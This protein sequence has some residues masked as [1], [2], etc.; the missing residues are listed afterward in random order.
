MKE[1]NYTDDEINNINKQTNQE[2][3]EEIEDEQNIIDYIK[4]KDAPETKVNTD[5]YNDDDDFNASYLEDENIMNLIGRGDEYRKNHPKSDNN[6]T[7]DSSDKNKQHIFDDVSPDILSPLETNPEYFQ[8]L[9]DDYCRDTSLDPKVTAE[10]DP[11]VKKTLKTTL[12]RKFEGAS[13]IDKKFDQYIKLQFYINESRF[14]G[15]EFTNAEYDK[16]DAIENHFKKILRTA[17][18]SAAQ[19]ILHK[20]YT[21]RMTYYKNFQQEKKWIGEIVPKNDSYHDKKTEFIAINSSKSALM[22]KTTQ[23]VQ[24]L[25]MNSFSEDANVQTR[26]FQE[27]RPNSN[28]TMGQF[29]EKIGYK[30]PAKKIFLDSKKA[31]K[32]DNLKAFYIN[33][34]KKARFKEMIEQK[35]VIVSEDK[36][37]DAAANPEKYNKE[38]YDSIMVSDDDLYG[39]IAR[40]LSIAVAEKPLLEA[41]F[42]FIKKKGLNKQQAETLEIVDRKFKGEVDRKGIEDWAGKNSLTDNKGKPVKGKNIVNVMTSSCGHALVQ[43]HHMKPSSDI[44]YTNYLILHSGYKATRS[45][46]KKAPENLAKSI[47]ATQQFLVREKFNLDKIHKMTEVVKKLPSFK[48][49]EHEPVIVICTLSDVAES[50]KYCNKFL[51]KVYGITPDK[52]EEYIN[53]MET[54]YNSMQPTGSQSTEYRNFRKSIE[55]IKNLKTRYDLNTED[56]KNAAS[57]ALTSLNITMINASETYMKGKKSVRSGPEG[58]RRF[59]NSLDAL[60]VLCSYSADVK[61]QVQPIV[62]R[63]NQVRDV[64]PGHKDFVNI[65]NFNETRAANAR[66][67][68]EDQKKAQEE[69]KKNSKKNIKK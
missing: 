4:S 57:K 2:N 18:T 36:L 38:A 34:I 65:D 25:L 43:D 66:K 14:A 40:D 17:K 26:L 35:Q 46:I 24:N 69:A 12:D 56:G 16:F 48:E 45:D 52:T 28:M 7:L 20:L 15:H 54:L 51:N 64:K 58:Q 11:D 44:N 21:N 33:V 61:A 10:K 13:S 37:E 63:I 27:Y 60:G 67:A 31:N 1:T 23:D 47:A 41:K 3:T 5:K 8:K 22:I 9:V 6:I 32:N 59:N 29:A 49:I 53:K 42:D 68:I 62:N 19:K 30:G 50:T 39:A 55:N